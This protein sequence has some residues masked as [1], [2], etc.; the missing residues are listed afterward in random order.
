MAD[1]PL[2]TRADDRRLDELRRVGRTLG[3]LIGEPSARPDP[4]DNYA[5]ATPY[6]LTVGE[7]RIEWARCRSAGWGPWELDLRLLPTPIADMTGVGR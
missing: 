6:G 1:R 5:F 3:T 4:A 7:L 2:H